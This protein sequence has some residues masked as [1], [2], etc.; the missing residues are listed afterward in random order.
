MAKTIIKFFLIFVTLVLAQVIIF[1][2]VCLYNVAIP[3][4]FLYLIVRLPISLSSNWTMTIGF[5]T[6]FT[7]D[8]FSDT[9]GM[10]ALA[11]TLIG[12]M[13]HGVLRLYIPREDDL[14]Q[15]EPS[16]RTLGTAV[17]LKYI[18]TISLIYCTTVF[19]IEACTF[20]NPMLLI[21]RIVCSSLLTS[22]LLVCIDSLTIQQHEKRL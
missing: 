7:V 20:F 14:A 8:I 12:V 3:F 22:V 6:G 15:S 21:M 2:H 1:N 13:R 5:I 17:Y 9:L 19:I 18:I 16:L 11:C 10:N 4:V